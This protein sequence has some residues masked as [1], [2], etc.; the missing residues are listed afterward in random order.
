MAATPR[1]GRIPHLVSF[2]SPAILLCRAARAA[3]LD[4]RGGVLTVGG[5]P[6]TPARQATLRA[7]GLRV[8]SGY[9]TT[10]AGGIATECLAPEASGDL[11]VQLDR[12]VL[13][14][15]GP[16]VGSSGLPE[17]GLLATALRPTAPVV[18]LNASLGDQGRLTTR[19]CRCPLG[20]LGWTVHLDHLR[21]F[22]KLTAGGMTFHDTRQRRRRPAGPFWWRPTD[23]Q[24]SPRRRR[25]G[26]LHPAIHP[27]RSADE[28]PW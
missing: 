5:E 3:G 8:M 17:D 20:A 18:L 9:A 1:A 23:Y 22:E 4:L 24:L 6:L 13:I 12:V 7:S 14:Q 19:A 15:P 27:D 28:R 26:P 11:H 16:A 10:E 25:R 2:V 21:S